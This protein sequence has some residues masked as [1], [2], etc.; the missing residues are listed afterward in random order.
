MGEGHEQKNTS[1]VIEPNALSLF[2]A[3]TSSMYFNFRAIKCIT[4]EK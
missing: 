2:D 1:P 3:L 4:H